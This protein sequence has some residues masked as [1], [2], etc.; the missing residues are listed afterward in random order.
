M[1]LLLL[2]KDGNASVSGVGSGV[3]RIR[4]LTSLC[5]RESSG[6]VLRWLLF[7]FLC[8]RQQGIF[9]VCYFVRTLKVARGEPMNVWGPQQF[10]SFMLV[11][12]PPPATQQNGH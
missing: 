8:Q 2:R 10:L 7:L 5:Y 3:V 6:L 9:C 11:H 1:F 4:L 12:T